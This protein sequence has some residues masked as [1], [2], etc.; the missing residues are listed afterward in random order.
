[1]TVGPADVRADI[2]SGRLKPVYLLYGE[3]EYLR[4]EAARKLV[5]ACLNPDTRDF[6]L[7]VFRAGE[8]HVESVAAALMSPPAFAAR[9]VVVLRGFDEL[10]SEEQKAV[11]GALQR[12]PQTSVAIL[13]AATADERTWAC[14]AVAQMGMV[15]RYRR[16]YESEAASWLAALARERGVNLRPEASEYLVRTLGSSAARL[17]QGFE[18]AC[19]YAGIGAGGATAPPG[20]S[21]AP[22]TVT[23]AHVMA[24]SAGEPSLGIFDLVDAV[25]QRD[26]AKAVAA[27]RRLLGFG[28]APTRILG[29]VARQVRLIMQTKILQGEGITPRAIASATHLQDFMIRKYLAQARN[30]DTEDLEDAFIALA[31]ADVDLKTSAA[32]EGVVLE[33]LIVRLCTHRSRG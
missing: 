15:V 23:L 7:A 11:V 18:K 31:G 3:E 32:P 27:A 25:G 8:A 28:E 1:M 30:F 29:M 5:D 13:V 20:G 6:N 21:G 17:A 12:M 33:K 19:D 16:L 9:R 2:K 10:G 22:R 14:K 4:D 26:T 24:A